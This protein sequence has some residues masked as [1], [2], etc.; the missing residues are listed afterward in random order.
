MR[1]KKIGAVSEGVS[2]S[3]VPWLDL[4]SSAQVEIT[5]ESEEN[6]IESA[7]VPDSGP[8][9]RAAH[10]GKQM[11]RILFDRPINIG[12][13]VL[14]FRE[15]EQE[16]TQEFVLRWSPDGQQ[17]FREILRQQFTFSPPATREEIEDYSVQLNRLKALELE[18]IPDISGGAAHASLAQMRLAELQ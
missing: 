9:W 14:R 13:I 8:G 4:E 1:K 3:T 10:P 7:L 12:R 2:H 6:P 11:I 17:S 18:I 15:E 5:S 16:R